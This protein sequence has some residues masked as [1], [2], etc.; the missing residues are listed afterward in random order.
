MTLRA[1]ILALI[2]AIQIAMLAALTALSLAHA[3]EAVAAEV[4]AG[5]DTARSLVLATIGTL[6]GAVPPDRLMDALPERLVSLRHARIGVL[7][8]RTG[9]MR[10]PPAPPVAAPEVPG[11]FA[12]AIA[13]PV[14]ETRL[15]VVVEGRML[16]FVFIST[17]PGAELA[18]VWHDARVTLALTTLAALAQAVAIFWAVGRGLAPLSAIAAR[19]ADLARGDLAARVGRVSIPDLTPLAVSVDRLGDTLEAAQADRARLSREVVTRADAERRAIARDLHDEYGPCLFALRVEAEA[20]RDA[21]PGADMTPHAEAIAAIAAEI[22]RVNRALLDGLRPMAIGQLPLATVLRDTVDDLTRRYPDLRV[23]LD[24]PPD[25]PEP[26]EATALT[27]FRILQEGTTNVL[28]HACATT[29]AIRLWTDPAHIHLT[30]RDDGRGIPP[31]TPP[32]N[33]LSGMRERV[34]L[35]GGALDIRSDSMGTEL[36]ARMP[37][38][39]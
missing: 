14:Q 8:A 1:R 27:L 19:L 2:V 21:P 25:L 13:P 20:I 4:R 3:R 29:C 37:R 18:E 34:I 39:P 33:G 10:S 28:R 23:T 15:P 36:H 12:R 5:A 35:L 38:S 30:L 7:D 17:D 32:G 31:G 6:Q 24:L 11:W 26:D 9:E 16:G 22:T